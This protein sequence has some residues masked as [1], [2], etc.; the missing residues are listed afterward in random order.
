LKRLNQETF[1]LNF[2]GS[3][4]V[5]KVGKDLFFGD[6]QYLRKIPQIQGLFFQKRNYLPAESLR[7]FI[8]QSPGYL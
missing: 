8:L 1:V 3:L 2:K 6:A 4:D 5:V 7:H